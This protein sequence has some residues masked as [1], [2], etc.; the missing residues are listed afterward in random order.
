MST[1]TSSPGTELSVGRR[2]QQ[3][4]DAMLAY[5]LVFPATLATF[6]FGV[7]P[8]VS[9]LWESLKQGRPVTNEYVGL[10]QY[11]RSIG[12]L[13]YIAIIA[14]SALF[15]LMAYQAWARVRR[16]Q[17]DQP[18][19][20]VWLYLI[21]GFLVAFGAFGVT[22][23]WV[24]KGYEHTFS[25]LDVSVIWIPILLLLLGFGGYYYLGQ[26]HTKGKVGAYVLNTWLVMQLTLLSVLMIRYIYTEMHDDVEQAREV[27]SLILTTE[28]GNAQPL[29]P[30]E[31]DAQ[32][33]NV[34]IPEGTMVTVVID[35]EE[36]EL[37][38]APDAYGQIDAADV[39]NAT[40]NFSNN[41]RVQ[42]L[43]PLSRGLG[44]DTML[45]QIEGNLR[46]QV[47]QPGQQPTLEVPV[48][49]EDN[50]QLQVPYDIFTTG[51]VGEDVV[52]R[53]AYTTPVQNPFLAT[54]GVGLL[55]G[56]IFVISAARRELIT[57]EEQARR[58][59]WLG[60]LQFIAWVIIIALVIYIITHVQ[61]YR[62][63]AMSLQKLSQD[64][65]EVAYSYASG[66][67]DVAGLRVDRLAQRLMFFPQVVSITAG[68]LLI[69]AAFFIW[70]RAKD[71]DT[72]MGMSGNLFLAIMLMI[73][74]W[75]C[76]S[77][78]PS[79]IMMAG[80]EAM[81][82]RDALVRTAMYSIGTVPAQ[83]A[84]GMLLAYLMF[85]EVTVGKGM[86]RLIYFMPYITP[87]VATAT[88]FTVIFSLRPESLANKALNLF[89]ISDQ[90]WLQENDG[91]FS[92]MY[93]EIF[94]GDPAHFPAVFQGPSLA[95]F[96]IILFN[97]WVYSGY[98]AVIF[99]AGLGA[100]PGELYEAARVDGAGRWSAFR[101]ITFP[102]LSPVT[103]FLSMLSIIGT[104]KA[105]GSVYVLRNPNND[106]ADT[107]T[108]E[109]FVSLF[110]DNNRGYASALA[111]VLFG[112][113]MI[114]TIVQNRL[115][116]ERVFYG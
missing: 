50:A 59:A 32:Y 39:A 113:I 56:V 71:R 87:Q 30:P 63:T 47:T 115:S 29:R 109:I 98:N 27:A 103:F 46:L 79:T 84:I 9:G 25:A 83:L 80:T 95:L 37:P 70:N 26:N 2:R 65:F 28:V 92:V 43:V 53:S 4:R 76:I 99:L 17:R 57:D 49:L 81:E 85:Y 20:P 100:I 108:I 106:Y 111:F 68:A 78:L 1:Q 12:S 73:G 44:F 89:G 72:T 21:P 31:L 69:T 45:Y 114:L 93:A 40:I 38:L 62:S 33:V 35:D 8:V 102:L 7:Y 86:F 91:I 3:F 67:E 90:Q 6:V 52:A 13:A 19:D 36:Y 97:I 10:D 24:T 77:E 66:G 64:E 104:F 5:I 82:A 55:L 110:R 23:L 105:F 116:R 41:Q 18:S 88:V 94:N 11:I 60:L 58:F 101:H 96:T 74:G 16:I 14:L 15:C 112:V 51:E 61:F 75:L 34:D 54:L 107:F 42:V 48:I 22:T